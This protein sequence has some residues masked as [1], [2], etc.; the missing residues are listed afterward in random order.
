[1][2]MTLA[3]TLG[4]F[5][6]VTVTMTVSVTVTM[7]VTPISTLTLTLTLVQRLRVVPQTAQKAPS[8]QSEC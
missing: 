7:T 5:L 3:L 6:T 2:I 8:K 1:M 4:P